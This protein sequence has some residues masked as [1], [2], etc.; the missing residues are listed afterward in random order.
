MSVLDNMS[1][2]NFIWILIILIQITLIVIVGVSNTNKFN[3]KINK[4]NSALTSPGEIATDPSGP[5]DVLFEPNSTLWANGG[6]G[7][8][9]EPYLIRTNGKGFR[10]ESFNS[11]PQD[12]FR[13]VVVGDSCTFGWGVNRSDRYTDILEYRLNRNSTKEFQV[14]NLAVPGY[15]IANYYRVLKHRGLK[16]NPDL[17]VIGLNGYSDVISTSTVGKFRRRAIRELNTTNKHR[18]RERIRNY[19]IEAMSS[20]PGN[21]SYE[22]YFPRIENTSGDVPVIVYNLRP[23]SGNKKSYINSV[24]SKNNLVLIGSP[25]KFRKETEEEYVLK[26]GDRHHNEKGH[27]WLA[28]KLYEE[29]SGRT[30]IPKRDE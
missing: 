20:E 2:M 10:E 29:L 25:D 15:G 7:T 30:E 12:N 16:Y 14:L 27:R 8:K 17:I 26:K 11:S 22:K 6:T 23:S 3:K 13:I 5:I 21:D 28:E 1:R 19:K 4:K 9:I 24:V 18:L